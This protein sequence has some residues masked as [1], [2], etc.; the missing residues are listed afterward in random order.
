[1]IIL[2]IDPGVTGAVALFK[3]GRFLKVLDIPVK[4]GGSKEKKVIDAAALAYLLVEELWESYPRVYMERAH[5]MPGQG[6]SSTFGYGLTNGIIE[7]VL[8][9]LGLTSDGNPLKKVVP[10]VWKRRLHLLSNAH[11]KDAGLKKARAL[12]PEAPLSLAKHHN[13]ADAILIGHYGC[14]MEGVIR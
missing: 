14:L 10:A 8:A 13:R 9:A 3:D 7:G 11:P 5:A 1:M 4:P 2:G 12:Y 6:V